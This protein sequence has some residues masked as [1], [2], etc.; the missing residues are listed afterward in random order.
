MTREIGFKVWDVI[1]KEWFDE[2][3]AVLAQD[4]RLKFWNTYRNQLE[5]LCEKTYLPLEFT[6][7]K[8]KNG[9]W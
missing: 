2:T 3:M 1:N 5:P 8:D 9:K 4:G 6:G 7:L